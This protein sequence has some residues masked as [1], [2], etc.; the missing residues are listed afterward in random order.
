MGMQWANTRAAIA[1]AAGAL[2]LQLCAQGAMAAESLE[3]AKQ[4]VV[5]ASVYTERRQ[6]IEQISALITRMDASTSQLQ[7][8]RKARIKARDK[9][10][11]A[12]TRE[13]NQERTR[14]SELERKLERAPDLDLSRFPPPP[15][16]PRGSPASDA[17]EMAM[18]DERK[19]LGQAHK[20]LAQ[21]LGILS[22]HYDEQLRIIAS[23]RN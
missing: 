9:R 7:Q 23:L 6:L 12:L 13:F 11:S 16:A 18:A 4:L 3:R 8:Y 19:R 2:A 20:Q 15:D 21:A 17:Y 10:F 14:V 22:D 1:F 5:Q